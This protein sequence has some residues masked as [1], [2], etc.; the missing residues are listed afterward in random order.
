[1]LRIINGTEGFECHL[2]NIRVIAKKSIFQTSS[3]TK[4]RESINTNLPHV[5]IVTF[6]RSP[7]AL[8]VTDPS[9]VLSSFQPKISVMTQDCGMLCTDLISLVHSLGC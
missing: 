1:M 6:Y 3:I 7:E 9:Q 8:Q 2:T 5:S 4:S